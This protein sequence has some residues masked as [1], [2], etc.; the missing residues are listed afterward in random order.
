MRVMAKL[1]VD[2]KMTEGAFLDSGIAVY[3]FMDGEGGGRQIGID[4]IGEC[5]STWSR[6][7]LLQAALDYEKKKLARIWVEA[8]E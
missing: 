7:G 5:G 3:E 1:E 2:Y 8:D 6:V 4:Y